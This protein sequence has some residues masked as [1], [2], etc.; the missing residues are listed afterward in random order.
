MA[1]IRVF[2]TESIY[3]GGNMYLPPTHKWQVTCTDHPHVEAK[4][5]PGHV[6]PG[7]WMH[8]A[9]L[10]HALNHAREYHNPPEPDPEPIDS[11]IYSDA[12][13]DADR[14]NVNYPRDWSFQ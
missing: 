3:S 10:M 12:D 6:D 9:A 11:R 14:R 8:G 5:I 4:G 7:F 2:A 1:P 13:H